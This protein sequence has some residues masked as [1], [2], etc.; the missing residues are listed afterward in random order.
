MTHLTNEQIKNDSLSFKIFPL[1]LCNGEVYSFITS[2]EANPIK[3]VRWYSYMIWNQWHSNSP[4]K[5]GSHF[6]IVI[7]MSDEYVKVFKFV[8]ILDFIRNTLRFCS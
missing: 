7:D 5:F 8:D 6:C 1:R 4:N 3:N 2:L